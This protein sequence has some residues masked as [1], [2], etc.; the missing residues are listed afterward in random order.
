MKKL[1]RFENVNIP[2]RTQGLTQ[3]RMLLV[4]AQKQLTRLPMK[5]SYTQ[6]EENETNLVHIF[7]MAVFPAPD[8]VVATS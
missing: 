5:L 6:L 7:F 4:L 3:L 2:S 8:R 1:R